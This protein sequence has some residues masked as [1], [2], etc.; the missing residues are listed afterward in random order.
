MTV[1]KFDWS[2]MKIG[3]ILTQRGLDRGSISYSPNILSLVLHLF[4]DH[5]KSIATRS[6]LAFSLKALRGRPTIQ[7]A[8]V[9]GFETTLMYLLSP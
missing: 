1:A 8:V 4:L 7:K 2:Y 3:M 9:F 5:W 6:A